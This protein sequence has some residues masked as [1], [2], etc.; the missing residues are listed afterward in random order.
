ME[1]GE[2]EL[3]PLAIGAGL[4]G[5]IF[6]LVVMKSSPAGL[7]FKIGGFIL[8]SIICYFVFDKITNK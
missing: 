2:M 5:G 1:I 8:T 7:V 4:I 3:N 6:A